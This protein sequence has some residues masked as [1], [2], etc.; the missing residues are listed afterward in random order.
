MIRKYTTKE[1]ACGRDEKR[2]NTVYD[3]ATEMEVGKDLEHCNRAERG[4]YKTG[5]K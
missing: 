5:Y 4:T 1:T 2:K 3:P